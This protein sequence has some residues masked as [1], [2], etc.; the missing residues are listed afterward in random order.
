MP[1]KNYVVS[2]LG[3]ARGASFVSYLVIVAVVALGGGAAFVVLG[4]A[5]RDGAH[6]QAAWIA[7]LGGGCSAEQLAAK[8]SAASM[9]AAPAAAG[10]LFC[11][12]LGCRGI[13]C[14]AAGTPVATPSGPIAIDRLEAG[15]LVLAGDGE[16]GVAAR[17]VLST[18]RSA[19]RA[20]LAIAIAGDGAS[21]SDVLHVTPEHPFFTPDRGWRAAR[22]LE[23]GALVTTDRGLA[24][25][26]G[27]TELAALTTVFNLEVDDLHTYFVGATH[28]LVHNDCTTGAKAL[29]AESVGIEKAFGDLRKEREKELD[30]A[31]RRAPPPP[32]P[33]FGSSIP[34][35][36]P[37]GGGGGGGGSGMGGMGGGGMRGN[38]PYGGG[39]G[40][41][42]GN[43][44][45]GG[46]GGGGLGG[47]GP[48]GGGLGTPGMPSLQA[49]G[50]T[51]FGGSMHF[52]SDLTYEKLTVRKA[53]WRRKITETLAA[54]GTSLDDKKLLAKA[55]L[56]DLT[57]GDGP[58]KKDRTGKTLMSFDFKLED[59]LARELGAPTEAARR[60]LV[61]FANT[62]AGAEI[63][64]GVLAYVTSFAPGPPMTPDAEKRAAE[65]LVK[66]A[67]ASGLQHTLKATLEKGLK[68]EKDSGNLKRLLQLLYVRDQLAR[69]PKKWGEYTDRTLL[70]KGI[71]ALESDP[72]VKKQ[73]ADLYGSA[74]KDARARAIA[75]WRS[76]IDYLKSRAFE[77]LLLVHPEEEQA[78]IINDRI[79]P[80]ALID[81]D[82]AT[83]VLAHLASRNLAKAVAAMTEEELEGA[84]AD[85]F[86]KLVFDGHDKDLKYAADVSKRVAKVIGPLS[87]AGKIGD[88]MRAGSAELA[89]LKVDPATAARFKKVMGALEMLD[90]NG[91]ASSVSSALGV[92]FLLA[93]CQDGKA[94]KDRA[95]TLASFGTIAKTIDSAEGA[96]KLTSWGLRV[97]GNSLNVER[98]KDLQA[99]NTKAATVA[100]G[101]ATPA[102]KILLRAKLAGP[103][104]DLLMA[105]AAYQKLDKAAELGNVN[106]AVVNAGKYGTALV[107]FT[108][109]SYIAI[110]GIVGLETGPLAPVVWLIAAVGYI[111]FSLF[112]DTAEE[113]ILRKLGVHVDNN[114]KAKVS[115]SHDQVIDRE[116]LKYANSCTSDR[117]NCPGPIGDRARALLDGKDKREYYGDLAALLDP[118]RNHGAESPVAAFERQ[119]I[120]ERGIKFYEKH[121]A[122]PGTCGKCHT[123]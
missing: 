12:R 37:Y 121:G 84:L 77:E 110:A 115:F 76:K 60:A 114:V 62:P 31:R 32:L 116:I 11:D 46:G 47:N 27:V 105:V 65:G 13:A 4:R 107:A 94:W 41:M 78:R 104:G 67:F 120:R 39:G 71:K 85:A 66:S 64:P 5:M 83:E 19:R 34:Q 18:K 109:G 90:K 10:G 14:F 17:R 52:V 30:D 113:T 58:M 79:A 45:Y 87:K 33:N 36:G 96:V 122:A 54:P 98:L 29:V 42:G 86:E 119:S 89:A 80:L 51:V 97:Y 28:A 92:F 2:I 49:P 48:Y 22:D 88:I 74:E 108:A 16:R 26:A 112:E 75:A 9:E 8:A 53:E 99:P 72:F 103:A 117:R 69:D 111:G 24:H 43:G 100:A 15:D 57:T 81:T 7:K 44:P 21:R 95:A 38:G 3:P 1:Y 35:G 20:V 118:K 63:K 101:K 25:I 40:G 56:D 82:T 61:D 73:L 70:E 23:P 59:K 55:L 68:E 102:A 123:K 106:N 50:S 91:H 6:C 93:D